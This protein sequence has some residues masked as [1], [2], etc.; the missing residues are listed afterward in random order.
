MNV[1]CYSCGLLQAMSCLEDAYYITLKIFWLTTTLRNLMSMACIIKELIRN[2]NSIGWK[3]ASVTYSCNSIE[4][5]LLDFVTAIS[6]SDKKATSYCHQAENQDPLVKT[7]NDAF[8]N[9]KNLECKIILPSDNY[10][11]QLI[12]WT[13]AGKSP[14]IRKTRSADIS[15]TEQFPQDLNNYLFCLY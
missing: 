9:G 15:I 5:R 14:Q 10:F 12:V 13:G 7:K 6:I 3:Q 11:R 8:V 4:V 2:Y 1:A